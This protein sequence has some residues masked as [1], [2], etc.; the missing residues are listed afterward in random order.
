MTKLNAGNIYLKSLKDLIDLND[1]EGG[2]SP[3][4]QELESDVRSGTS[5]FE[6][7]S[8]FN[9]G[10]L[11]SSKNKKQS[12]D[13]TIQLR[14]EQRAFVQINQARTRFKNSKNKGA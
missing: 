11:M 7:I 2:R 9:T 3:I 10:G 5:P 6:G 13:T 8:V 1:Q 14:P 4:E 12:D